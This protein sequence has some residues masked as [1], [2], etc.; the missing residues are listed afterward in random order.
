MAVKSS[1]RVH[2]MLKKKYFTKL[3]ARSYRSA[4]HK[5]NKKWNT[6]RRSCKDNSPVGNI[7]GKCQVEIF[8]K[9]T[10]EKLINATKFHWIKKNGLCTN[11]LNMF[12]NVEGVFPWFGEWETCSHTFRRQ[13]SMVH[14][15]HYVICSLSTEVSVC[16]QT[17]EYPGNSNHPWWSKMVKWFYNYL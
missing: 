1:N 12:N 16:M 6:Q 13:F 3:V 10:R 11:A 4:A 8:K 15:V 9:N 5:M 14:L 7:S 17:R 2:S